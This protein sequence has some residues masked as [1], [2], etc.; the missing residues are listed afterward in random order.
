M[1]EIKTIDRSDDYT[2]IDSI[3]QH[4]S[5]YGA[6]SVTLATIDNPDNDAGLPVG[7][8]IYVEDDGAETTYFALDEEESAEAK[9]DPAAYL[10]AAAEEWSRNG[11]DFIIE[12]CLWGL[13]SPSQYEIPDSYTG[14]CRILV[15]ESYYGYD[16]TYWE[17]DPETRGELVFATV[18]EARAWI[19]QAES[20]VYHLSHNEA[21]RPSY[22]IVAV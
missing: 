7:T 4:G 9:A 3:S 16:P 13:R 11:E 1:K 6:P 5:Q 10:R 8:V 20:G 18:A 17:Y 14:E 15:E 12:S 22:T 19:A 2:V 21:G